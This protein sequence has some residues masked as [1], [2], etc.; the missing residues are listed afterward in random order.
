MIGVLALALA[1]L[2]LAV[3]VHDQRGRRSGTPTRPT[4]APGAWPDPAADRGMPGGV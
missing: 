1:A 2:V 3:W 4:T